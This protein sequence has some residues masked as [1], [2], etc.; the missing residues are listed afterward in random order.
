MVLDQESDHGSGEIKSSCYRSHGDHI[1]VGQ[2]QHWCRTE[3]SK[4]HFTAV[5]K[6]LCACTV[7]VTV[8]VEDNK[9][10]VLQNEDSRSMLVFLPQR[11]F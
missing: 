1:S 2:M 6:L 11:L 10:V 7:G 3:M 8:A 4:V 5:L 9:R